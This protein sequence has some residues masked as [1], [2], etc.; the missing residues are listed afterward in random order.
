MQLKPVTKGRE[1]VNLTVLLLPGMNYVCTFEELV[2]QAGD[3]VCVHLLLVRVRHVDI[4][5]C[6]GICVV[7]DDL[8]LVAISPD[9]LCA[10]PALLTRTQRTHTDSHFDVLGHGE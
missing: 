7:N 9:R 2:D 1:R 4:V 8:R 6:K 5:E 10:A 3:G